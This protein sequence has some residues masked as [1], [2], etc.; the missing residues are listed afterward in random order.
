[1]AASEGASRYW[2]SRSC[3]LG[4]PLGFAGEDA[5]REVRGEA[6]GEQPQGLLADDAR[7]QRLGGRAQGLRQAHQRALVLE[8]GGAGR[9]ERL[10][11]EQVG[12]RRIGGEELEPG[13][14][15]G[16]NPIGPA[17][18]ACAAASTAAASRSTPSS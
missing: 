13:P 3:I 14:Q 6:T 12:E 4:E 9:G 1:M 17:A 18:L 11:Q 7:R 5:A 10:D 16:R 2:S 15:P 8:P